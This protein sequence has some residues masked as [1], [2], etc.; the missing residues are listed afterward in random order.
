IGMIPVESIL[1]EPGIESYFETPSSQRRENGN[2][3]AV[4]P[5]VIARR[6]A[7]NRASQRAFRRRKEKHTK[8][9]E[10]KLADLQGRHSELIHLYEALQLEYS[11][12]I[13]EI[14]VL[15]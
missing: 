1:A 14:Q 10:E 2:E 15:R 11:A 12:V 3:N 5:Y 8:E 7:Q 4:S 6:R 13:K 9:V